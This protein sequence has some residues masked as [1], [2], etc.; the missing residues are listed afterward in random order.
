MFCTECGQESTQGQFCTSCGKQLHLGGAASD[1]VAHPYA[2]PPK[3]GSHMNFNQRSTSGLPTGARIG[4][5]LA[6]L[7]V[8]VLGVV[9]INGGSSPYP[10]AVSACGLDTDTYVELADGDKTLII[11]TQGDD[12]FGGVSYADADCILQELGLPERINSRIG[13]TRALDGQLT[14]TWDGNTITWSYHP[15]T[16]ANYMLSRD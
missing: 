7:G 14:D 5:V 3:A 10:A 9:L 15:N 6:A 8:L 11:D 2:S 4:I 16:G 1:A 12:D 13:A